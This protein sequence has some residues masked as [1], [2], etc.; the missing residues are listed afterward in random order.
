MI[1]RCYEQA[2][3]LGS[4]I[5]AM[6]VSDSIRMVDDTDDSSQAIDRDRLCSVQTPQTFRADLLL[7]AFTQPY[8][9]A[10]TDEATVAEASGM[11]VYLIEGERS[12]IK[13]TTPDD[14]IIA[15]ALLKHRLNDA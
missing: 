10:F 12:N 6:R 9:V 5:P 15:E 14:M 8:H 13:V 4:A 7:P 3:K 11:N 2:V 1:K